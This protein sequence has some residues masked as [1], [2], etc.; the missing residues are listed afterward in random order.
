[1]MKK[2]I[3]ITQCSMFLG[4]AERALLSMLESFDYE[5]YD[6]DLFL[7]KHE[8]ELM[9][10]LPKEVKLLPEI[11]AYRALNSGIKEIICAH[12]L[13]AATK[14]A[15]ACAARVSR[16]G[17]NIYDEIDRWAA[18]ILPSI[19]PRTTYDACI[20]YLA[21]HRIERRHVKARQYI[22]WI[23]TDYAYLTRNA[24]RDVAG[25]AL[26]DRIISISP[27][28][29]SGFA[30]VFPSLADRLTMVENGVTRSL[31]ERQANEQDISGE[32]KG[33]LKLLS[34]GRFCHAKNFD[35]AVSIMA[36]L[37]KLRQD[38][39]WYIIG[40]GGDEPLIRKAISEYG[41]KESFHILGKRDNP[42]PYMKACD[43][44]VQP[45]R[46]EGKCVAVL[47]AQALGKPVAIT[48][49][50]TAAGQLEDGVDG[51]ILPSHEPS[52][53]AS[54][55]HQLLS[56]PARLQQLAETCSRRDYSCKPYL[57]NLYHLFS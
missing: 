48:P 47:E 3:L 24:Q 33:V 18:P 4:G 46:Y 5:R 13:I 43:L 52:E 28:V 34:V 19:N 57:P 44:Y 45:S 41:M 56:R 21:N 53:V 51:V 30:K 25:W 32:M 39:H 29:H 26:F 22:A 35:G 7:Y 50:P 8:G 6:V 38:V 55:L 10:Y 40:Y 54:A 11:P 49:Y 16:D 36:E 37:R 27:A 17:G 15:A 14:I 20:S 31:L 2:R 12:P 1:M 23:H 42:Y 9:E